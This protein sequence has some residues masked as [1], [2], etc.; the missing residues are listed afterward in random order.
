MGPFNN[1]TVKH[2]WLSSVIVYTNLDLDQLTTVMI[3]I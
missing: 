1:N 3:A 2:G